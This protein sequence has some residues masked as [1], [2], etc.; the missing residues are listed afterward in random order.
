M[1]AAVHLANPVF[2]AVIIGW[3]L[4]VV[5]HEFAHG[6]VGSLGGDYTVRERGGLSLNPL[7]YID[8]VM[9]IIMPALFIVMGGIPLPGGAT[10]VRT[11][12]LRNRFWASAVSAA[13]PSTNFIIFLALALPFHPKLNWLPF[14]DDPRNWTQL[15]LFLGASALLQLLAVFLNLLPIPP[16]DG[17]GIIAPFL[18]DNM[19][20]SIRSQ[21]GQ[22]IGLAAVFIL[23]TTGPAQHAI[24]TAMRSVFE[25]LQFGDAAYFFNV[26]ADRV[27]RS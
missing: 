27:L 18:P 4:T 6:L 19:R 21:Q 24:G 12:L 11:D 23:M 15:Q 17:F 3:I 16:L 1:L 5:L 14:D 2:W 7:Q 22:L 10:Y 9:S 25:L 13:G 26:C 20:Q 8:P